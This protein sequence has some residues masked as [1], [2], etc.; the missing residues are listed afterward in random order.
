M[1]QADRLKPNPGSAES[2]LSDYRQAVQW[3]RPVS[4]ELKLNTDGAFFESSGDGGW[5]YVLRDDQG[6]VLKDGAGREDHLISAFHAELLGCVAGLKMVI[7]L[8]I[9][10]VTL[11]TDAP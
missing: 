7:S 4:G 5:G 11:E 2:L 6:T 1:A 8:G 3:R 9:S 10:S